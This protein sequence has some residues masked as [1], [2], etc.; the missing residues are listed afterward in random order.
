MS[1]PGI[2]AKVAFLRRPDAYPDP[3]RRVEALETHMSW[4]FLTDRHAYK[5]KKPIRYDSLDFSSRELRRLDCEA[6]VRLN[7][8]LAREVYLG[9]VALTLAPQGTL[10]L[11]G[12]GEAVDWLVHM[13]RLPAEQM[14]DRRIQTRQLQEAHVRPAALRLARFY[15]EAQPV[16]CSPAA[17]RKHLAEGVCSDRQELA[18]PEFDLPTDR[19]A[20]LAE[21]QLGFLG[22]H[23]ALFDRR[24][25]DGHVVE[26]HGDLRPEHICLGPE[27]AIIDC[28]E[29]S[30]E[31]RLLDPADELAFLALECE[32]LGEPVVGR[33]FLAVYAEVTGDAPP[34]AL[35]RFHRSYRALRRAKI[36]IWHLLDPGV[37]TP[38]HWR[39]RAR[40]YLAL[41]APA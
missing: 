18:R 25:R 30:R 38:E 39:R 40:Q 11:D 2:E 26:G 36:A 20:A 6:E 5:L 27:P 16:E 23:A 7:R 35:L 31:L 13:R 24:V 19:V 21:A 1:E 3:P 15:A 37:R 41:A 14:L 33:W 34:E 12:V 9:T 29:F 17:Y 32:R 4:V 22:E 28:L 8:R 10:A